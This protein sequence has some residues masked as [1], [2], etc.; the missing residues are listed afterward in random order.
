MY[1]NFNPRLTWR[2]RICLICKILICLFFN[3]YSDVVSEDGVA[4]TI[5]VEEGV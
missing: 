2:W 3:L 4:Q 1:A 5:V